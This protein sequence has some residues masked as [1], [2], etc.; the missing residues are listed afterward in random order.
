[1]VHSGDQKE[2]ERPKNI[3]AAEEYT[4]NEKFESKEQIPT[5]G[6]G[7]ASTMSRA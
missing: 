4:I 3:I 2:Y 5:H 7:L 6:S 1:M